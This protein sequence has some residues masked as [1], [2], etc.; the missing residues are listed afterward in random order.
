MGCGA[1][2]NLRLGR[3][4]SADFGGAERMQA[5][6]ST[7]GGVAVN[8]TRSGYASA[9]GGRRLPSLS[10]GV[11]APLVMPVGWWGMGNTDR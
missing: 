1:D 6:G 5:G 8:R 4:G 7:M 3:Q 9:W 10:I 11:R 2:G